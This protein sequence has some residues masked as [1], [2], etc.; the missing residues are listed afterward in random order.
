[1]GYLLLLP[2]LLRDVFFMAGGGWVLICLGIGLAW[3]CFARLLR[4][5]CRASGWIPHLVR[6]RAA[7]GATLP[8]A[9][10]AEAAVESTPAEDTGHIDQLFHQL[11]HDNRTILDHSSTHATEDSRDPDELIAVSY[12]GLRAA[13]CAPSEYWLTQEFQPHAEAEDAV[14]NMVRRMCDYAKLCRETRPH[15]AYDDADARAFALLS[16]VPRELL[17]DRQLHIAAIAADYNVP[18]W[19]LTRENVQYA[20][21]LF[22]APEQPH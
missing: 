1:M 16:N 4:L 8:T 5:L 13:V 21:N 3:M 10:V 7:V 22:P 6:R 14:H 20:C 18:V 9:L 17:T 12:L 2:Q 15:I 19:E 11:E